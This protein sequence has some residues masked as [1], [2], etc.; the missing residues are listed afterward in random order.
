MR[1]GKGIRNSKFEMRKLEENA[2]AE[3][4]NPPSL[5]TSPT[6]EELRRAPE[7]GWGGEG[8]GYLGLVIGLWPY[9]VPHARYFEE[10]PQRAGGNGYP[11]FA[12]HAL[13]C[14]FHGWFSRSR[15]EWLGKRG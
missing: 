14:T 13:A 1:G 4:A 8:I 10:R 11:A 6:Q 3:V 5:L 15:N 7:A 2:H 12:G 9:F